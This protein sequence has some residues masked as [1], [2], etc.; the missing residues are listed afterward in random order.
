VAA[1]LEGS[2]AQYDTTLEAALENTVA[3]VLR[4]ERPF[5]VN[6]SRSHGGASAPLQAA[7]L[8]AVASGAADSVAEKLARIGLDDT[9]LS[10]GSSSAAEAAAS[11]HLEGGVDENEPICRICLEGADLPS[12]PLVVPCACRGS[13]TWAHDSC[14]ANWRRTS[15]KAEAAFRCGQCR[16]DYR[17]ALSLRLLQERLDEQR[18]TDSAGIVFTVAELGNQLFAQGKLDR[19]EPLLCE[20]LQA[21]R[22]TLGPRHPNTLNS[23]NSL[24]ML[25]RAQGDLAGAEPLLRESLKA[26]R[27]TLGPRHPDTLSSINN[28]G[29][30]LRDQGDAADALELLRELQGTSQ[31]MLAVICELEAQ[32]SKSEC[33]GGRT[34]GRKEKIRKQQ[35]N[36]PI[37]WKKGARVQLQDLKAR[38]DLNGCTGVLLDGVDERTGRVPVKLTAPT[39]HAGERLRVKPVNLCPTT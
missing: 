12:R 14:L 3:Q 32:V 20:A 33:S 34:K 26:C 23:I 8:Q 27:N 29:M 6:T 10:F 30:L 36:T 17:D 2:S 1:E 5:N 13:S 9:Q 28:L 21:Y 37:V 11:S 22:E 15:T 19:A 38:A 25:L 18:A 4:Y 7:L 39:A 16:D 35:R 31:D 24:G